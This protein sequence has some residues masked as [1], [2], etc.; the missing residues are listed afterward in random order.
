M[1]L[2]EE[3]K[4]RPVCVQYISQQGVRGGTQRLLRE[5]DRSLL[6][7]C[8]PIAYCSVIIIFAL[9]PIANCHPSVIIIFAPLITVNA[10]KIWVG[11]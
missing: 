1:H 2:T 4:Y 11:P 8:C 3:E 6:P 5:N 9:L 10:H 7:K